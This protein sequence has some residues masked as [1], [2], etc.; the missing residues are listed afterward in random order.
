MFR[1][2]IDKRTT[3]IL[4]IVF[5]ALILIRPDILALLV[6]VYLLVSGAMHFVEK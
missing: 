4:S 1:M 3:A 2:K 5:G 6:G